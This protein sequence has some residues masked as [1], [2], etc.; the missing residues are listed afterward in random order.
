MERKEQRAA[1]GRQILQTCRAELCELFP[2]LDAAFQFLPWQLHETPGIY[3]DTG[4]LHCSVQELL[5][6]YHRDPAAV[7]R[8]YLHVLLHCLYGHPF[9]EKE[10]RWWDLACDISVEQMIER[11]GEERLHTDNP[12]R[13]ACLAKLGGEILS[14][15]QIIP[16]L[17]KDYFARSAE[18]LYRAFA[19]DDPAR[20]CTNSARGLRR[21]W[22][23]L[24]LEAA[25]NKAG[26]G[27]R[28][29][30]AGAEEV[31]RQEVEA[32]KYD[33]RKFLRQFT[34][35]REEVELD[36]ESFDY[37]LYQ[38]GMVYCN[39]MPLIEPLEYK[40]VRRLEELVIA[41]DTSHSC[42]RETVSRFL[43]ET[44]RILSQQENFFRK[45]KVYFIQCDCLIQ[46]VAVIHSR[47]EWLEYAK[48]ITVHG[49]GGTDFSPVFSYIEN[50]RAQKKLKNLRAL[51]YFTDGD[52]AYPTQPPDY[53]TAFI[54]LRE[55]GHRELVPKWA[56]VL[57]I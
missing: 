49:R 39:A 32:S 37:I 50:L 19:F 10:G 45:M 7:R 13:T 17:E 6:C 11:Q 33:Y 22:E 16:L 25:Q 54:L 5:A 27:K 23:S 34:F 20:W 43:N 56:R 55:S 24:L 18:E 57:L 28:G 51:L 48:Q 41:I 36:T 52:G 29:S 40:E 35:P 53:E 44:Y 47:E 9:S 2:Y 21:E 38:Y 31:S 8:G 12:L 46:R 26:R 42:S 3:L 1:L 15:Q 30:F 14:A 4:V